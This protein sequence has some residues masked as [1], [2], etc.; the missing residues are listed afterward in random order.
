MG[1]S[2]GRKA[3]CSALSVMREVWSQ[4]Q[5]RYL[6]GEYIMKIRDFIKLNTDIDVYDDVCEELGI[7]FCGPIML[8]EEGEQHFSEVLDYDVTVHLAITS[9]DCSYATVHVD[10]DD[11]KVWK[12]RLRKAKE[13]FHSLAGYC[14][15]DDYEKWFIEP[16]WGQYASDPDAMVNMCIYC[17]NTPWYTEEEMNYSNLCDLDFPRKLVQEFYISKGE[18]IMTFVQWLT[19]ECTADDTDGLWQF[20]KDR[21]FIAVR[22]PDERRI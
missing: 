1:S 14:S 15:E 22:E 16:E 19:E 13:F 8:T 5:T 2:S 9:R 4:P 12:R 21:G 11:D 17:D 6:K 18:S 3:L 7:C 20:C 10:D